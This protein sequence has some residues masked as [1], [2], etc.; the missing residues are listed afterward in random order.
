VALAGQ[1][2]VIDVPASAEQKALI[3]HA[4]YCLPNP[5]LGHASASGFRLRECGEC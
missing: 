1:A 2:D 4:P 5:E 3:F